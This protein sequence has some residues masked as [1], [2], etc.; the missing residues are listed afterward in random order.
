[1]TVE[2][3][4]NGEQDALHQLVDEWLDAEPGGPRRAQ[5][6][7]RLAAT[8]SGRMWLAAR[9]T[10]IDEAAT[11]DLV[12]GTA[13]AL[14][15]V[16]QP[17]SRPDQA[18]RR[19]RLFLGTVISLRQWS[20]TLTALAALLAAWAGILLAP[21]AGTGLSGTGVT[22]QLGLASILLFALAGVLAAVSWALW[23]RR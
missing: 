19:R 11:P 13:T 9:A 15:E 21:A 12:A 8:P 5:L 20:A 4:P 17:L 22:G 6:A 3:R 7:A 14:R 16:E 2:P 1:M 18:P 10:L 23:Q